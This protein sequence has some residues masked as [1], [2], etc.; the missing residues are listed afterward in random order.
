VNTYELSCIYGKGHEHVHEH[1]HGHGHGHG[2]GHR[3]T[4]KACKS[5]NPLMWTLD[6]SGRF[7]HAKEKRSTGDKIRHHFEP[8]MPMAK[9]TYQSATGMLL[10][11]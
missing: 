6:S 1:E 8:S 11:E 10:Q 9:L 2:N 3:K 7:Q 5:N 4:A